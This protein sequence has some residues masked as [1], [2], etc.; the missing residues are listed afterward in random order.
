MRA[1]RPPEAAS[2]LEDHQIAEL[3]V[4]LTDGRPRK[5]IHRCADDLPPT[6]F[7][8]LLVVPFFPSQYQ[9]LRGIDQS[10][11]RAAHA[12]SPPRSSSPPGS[13]PRPRERA[14]RN[15]SAGTL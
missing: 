10:S 6:I 2:A 7:S 3:A 14:S 1:G 13:H 11:F 5:L 8:A 9:Y 15:R 4:E 12:P